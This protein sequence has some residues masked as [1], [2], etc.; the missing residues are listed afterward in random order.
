MDAGAA[1]GFGLG[2]ML[3]QGGMG[4]TQYAPQTQGAQGGGFFANL[5]NMFGG[6]QGGGQMG[7]LAGMMQGGMQ[8]GQGGLDMAQLAPLLQMMQQQQQQQQ[9]PMQM[10]QPMQ[11][12]AAPMQTQ[13]QRGYLAQGGGIAPR[14]IINRG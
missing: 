1:P 7:G 2:Q 13:A 6:G 4:N 14:T 10:M 12:N 3:M 5:A 9:Q 8:G 11:R